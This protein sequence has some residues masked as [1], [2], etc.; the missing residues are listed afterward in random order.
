MELSHPYESDIARF[1]LLYQLP[2]PENCRRSLIIGE[3]AVA[4]EVGWVG[5]VIEPMG[6]SDPTDLLGDS[7]SDHFDAIALPGVLRPL[8]SRVGQT[9]TPNFLRQLKHKLVPGGVL[10]GHLNHGLFADTLVQPSN[11]PALLSAYAD[12]RCP[13]RASRLLDLLNK[14][15]LSDAKCFY[16][17]PSITAP[18]GLI[19]ACPEL[20]KP[21][22]LRSLSGARAGH[23]VLAYWGRRLVIEVGLAS[24]LRDTLFFWARRPC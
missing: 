18:M 5:D 10:I 19:P 20:V 21:Y 16:V 1:Q 2:L 12:R 14:A 13:Y 17:L 8:S 23:A 6:Q 11:W 9:D 22:F 7:P 3:N 15:G 24:A 4:R